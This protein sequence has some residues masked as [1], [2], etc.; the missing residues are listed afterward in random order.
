MEKTPAVLPISGPAWE[1]GCGQGPPPLMAFSS[2]SC[3]GHLPPPHSPLASTL[4]EPRALAEGC[5]CYDVILIAVQMS[6]DPTITRLAELLVMIALCPAPRQSGHSA[7]G[8]T[9]PTPHLTNKESATKSVVTEPRF[10]IGGP[11]IDTSV[12]VRL[13]D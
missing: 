3:R 9:S 4:R 6:L 12:V 5:F 1:L 13:L 7:L 11:N 2:G 10:R 8:I